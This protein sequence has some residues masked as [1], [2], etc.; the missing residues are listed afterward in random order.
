MTARRLPSLA[1]AFGALLIIAAIGFWPS[2]LSRIG[3]VSS[4]FVHVH[5]VVMGLWCL[6]L[7]GQIRLVRAGRAAPHG[8]LGEFIAILI[9]LAA[10]GA[11]ALAVERLKVD[12]SPDAV[13]PLYV[14][15]GTIALFRGL[16]GLAIALRG[17]PP[18]HAR[19]MVAGSLTMID[20]VLAR[21]FLHYTP[22]W[23]W[24]TD[25]VV[26]A[27]TI[28]LLILLAWRDRSA[29]A[30]AWVFPASALLFA[31]YQIGY[32][33]LARSEAWSRLARS[34]AWVLG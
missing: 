3:S 5:A 18:V 8:R 24:L 4:P 32:L 14:Q 31:V 19:L 21:V 12:G 1:P 23:A 30:V 29:R 6:G 2:Y 17:K 25:W 7:I 26:P 10:T 34:L 28:P 15:L 16:T 20:P 13:I 11:L 33:T 22:S 9:P 27:V